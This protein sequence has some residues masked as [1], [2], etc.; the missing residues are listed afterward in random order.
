MTGEAH[1]I[2]LVPLFV[3]G[4]G[5]ALLFWIDARTERGFRT[6]QRR[7]LCPKL[8]RKVDATLVRDADSLK[9]IG[10]RRCSG[11]RDPDYVTCARIC[12]PGFGPRTRATPARA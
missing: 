5:I 9:V 10:V 3:G 11:S 8:K 4:L 2:A 12:V 7:F 6:E 1:W